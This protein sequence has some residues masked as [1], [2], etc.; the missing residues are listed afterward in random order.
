MKRLVTCESVTCGH[1]DKVCDQVADAILDAYKKEDPESHVAVEV[2]MSYR[3]VFVMGEVPSKAKIEIET[4]IRKTICEIGY[5]HDTLEFNGNTIPIDIDIR[6]QSE[7]ISMGVDQARDVVG[8]LG[9]GDQGMMYGYACS[10]TDNK[11]PY[12][13]ELATKLAHRLEVVR[14]EQLIP[15]LRP[16]G[17]T[18]VTVEYD[19]EEPVRI[20]TILISTQHE[21]NIALAQLRKDLLTHVIDPV[22][23][24]RWDSASIQILVNPTGRFVL[25]GPAA[26]SGLTGRKIIAD[27]YGGIGHHGGGAFSGKDATKVDRTAAYYTRYVA[28]NL[29]AA[30]C[31]R[32]C[33]V[34]VSYAIG[35][36]NP[37]SISIDTFDTARYPEETL[38][39][40]I[41]TVFDFRPSQMIE[42]LSLDKVEFQTLSNYGHFGWNANKLSWEQT[43]KVEAIKAALKTL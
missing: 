37:I 16:D 34:S 24:A 10:D 18:Q 11:M 20:Q 7:D 43:D 36:A 35:V 25:G 28:K 5:D 29:V 41:E 40:V 3:R 38:L 42:A 39:H 17:K 19:G 27:T 21:P 2:S 6:T 14:K 8:Q 31:C 12:P 32:K 30:N 33:E 23:E 4:L 1:P 9:A 26:D 22:L 15:Y 13:Y